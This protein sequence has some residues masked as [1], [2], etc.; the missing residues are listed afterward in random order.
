[1]SYNEIMVDVNKISRDG[2]IM[3]LAYDQGFEHG[4]TD[5]DFPNADP[6]FVIDV[7]RKSGVFTGIVF[8]VGVAEKYYMGERNHLPPLILKLNGKTN[9]HQGE[10]PISL[11]L[12][13][14]EKAWDLGAVG[15]GYT[16][17]VGSE[18]EQ[19]MMVEFRRICD[20]AHGRGMVVIVWMYPRGKHVAGRET[21]RDVVAYAGR[22]ALEM[23]ADMAKLP[24]TGDTESFKWVVRSA[25]RTHVLVQGGTKKEEGQLLGEVK[26]FMQAGATGMAVGRNVWQSP[27]P[28]ETARKIAALVYEV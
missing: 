22:L 24:Y 16:I 12:T 23:G 26:G 18:H 28:V 19:Q 7:A 10:E 3:L 5:F 2:K 9:F 4:P 20:E 13:S 21:S 1:M 25:G 14:V 6:D 11:Q 8:Q 15:V 17:Y 27:D